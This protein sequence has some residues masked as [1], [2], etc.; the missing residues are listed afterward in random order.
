MSSDS[1]LVDITS[2]SVHRQMYDRCA[3]NCSSDE[4]ADAYVYDDDEYDDASV[5]AGGDNNA[6]HQAKLSTSAFYT[7]SSDIPSTNGIAL[8]ETISSVAHVAGKTLPSALEFPP[9]SQKEILSRAL[10]LL[11]SQVK[12]DVEDCG[13]NNNS[14]QHDTA[15]CFRHTVNSVCHRHDDGDRTVETAKAAQTS[16]KL[17]VF[18]F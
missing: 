6:P 1:D 8:A 13:G 7:D 2:V 15:E 3:T 12:H 14:L 4:Q 18:N 5:L 11:D 16:G 10:E 17:L 9:F